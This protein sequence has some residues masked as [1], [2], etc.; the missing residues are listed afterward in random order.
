MPI[1]QEIKDK[2]FMADRSLQAAGM[3]EMPPEELQK[4][5]E[6][7]MAQ[8][9]GGSLGPGGGAMLP[10]GQMQGIPQ[11]AGMMQGMAPQGQGMPMGMAP[12]MQGMGGQAGI[13]GQGFTKR[14]E[15]DFDSSGKPS[16]I[17]VKMTRDGMKAV[18]R[19]G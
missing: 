2:L 6:M 12:A 3:G 17:V 4:Y 5:A 19:G 10:Q 16:Q 13:P 8:S 1:S 15:V 7:L 18:K 9:Q 14:L 11:Q